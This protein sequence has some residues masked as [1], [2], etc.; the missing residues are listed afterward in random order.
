MDRNFD[1]QRNQAESHENAIVR[2]NKSSIM[3]V[4][5][6]RDRW[7]FEGDNFLRELTETCREIGTREL[8]IQRAG[9]GD[10]TRDVQL[11][12]MRVV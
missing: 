7:E 9:N 1:V 12:K 5:V 3:S 10:R 2:S 6:A 8:L 4:H 11:G